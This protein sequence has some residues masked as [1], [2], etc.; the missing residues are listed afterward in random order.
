MRVCTVCNTQKDLLDFHKWARSTDGYR[1]QC[2]LCRKEIRKLEYNKN[3]EK[4]LKQNK[5]WSL[6]N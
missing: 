2:K 5:E 3:K 1:R 6:K 4:I